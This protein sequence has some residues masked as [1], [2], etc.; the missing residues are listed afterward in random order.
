V[1]SPLVG[2]LQTRAAVVDVARWERTMRA[3]LGTT[4]RAALDSMRASVV[5]PL[6]QSGQPRSFLCF[7]P[8]RSGDIYTQTDYA[9]L[10]D[11]ARRVSNLLP[12]TAEAPSG[13]SQGL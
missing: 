1:N 10:T 7:G 6:G 5:F 8:K 12:D 9:L 13:A 11:V 4:D 2:A 3:H